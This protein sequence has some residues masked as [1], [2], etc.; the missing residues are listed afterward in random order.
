MYDGS[1]FIICDINLTSVGSCTRF[2]ASSCGA[3]SN[4]VLLEQDENKITF[5]TRF[6]PHNL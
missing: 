4:P 2:E 3:M 6:F 5:G 1:L